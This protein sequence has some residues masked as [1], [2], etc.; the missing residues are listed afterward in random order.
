MNPIV[1]ALLIQNASLIHTDIYLQTKPCMQ[2]LGYREANPIAS[3]LFEAGQF[4]LGYILSIAGNITLGSVGNQI[5][6]SGNLSSV[7]LGCISLAEVIAIGSNDKTQS[8]RGGLINAVNVKATILTI[9][10]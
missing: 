8:S 4:D 9:Q 7:L 3:P 6:K 1:L 2:N 5:D 10:F